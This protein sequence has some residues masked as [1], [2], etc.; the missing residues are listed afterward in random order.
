M[1]KMICL[2]L[3]V[4]CLSPLSGMASDMNIVSEDYTDALSVMTQDAVLAFEAD[5]P[6]GVTVLEP[7][8]QAMAM[9][10]EIYTFVW[11]EKNRPVRYYDEETQR[12]IEQ[13]VEGVDID[14][15]H[16]TEFMG[17]ELLGEPEE[18]VRMGA[19]LD[20]DY[21]PGQ[22]IVVVFALAQE[23]GTYRYFPYRGKVPSNGLIT[24]EVPAEEY[25]QMLSQRSIFHVLTDRIGARGH[26]VYQEEITTEPVAIP[27]KAADDL[28]QIRRW[29]SLNG[30]AIDDQFSIFVVEKTKD[31]Q[32][33]VKRIGLHLEEGGKAI[34]WFPEDIRDEA[35]LQLPV[36]VDVSDLVIYDIEALMAKD[37]KDTYGDV[38]TESQFAAAYS[39]EYSMTALLGFPIKDAQEAPYLEWHCLRAE[40]L[41]TVLDEDGCVE[42]VFKQLVIPTMEE[43]PAMLVV[44]SEPMEE[45][46]TE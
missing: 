27:S 38:A 22:L 34:D 45:K 21:R 31:M 32:E 6:C 12:K 46:V 39:P 23:D 26:A 20:V 11:E 35:Q 17:L 19:M 14:I 8:A 25:E 28:V 43:E 10:E 13:L 29:K 36:D 9:L 42:I 16:M 44:F 18:T 40:A 24:F 41:E 7:Y 30:E 33:E 4:L 1:K 3:L 5:D 37:Y 2:L 15:L